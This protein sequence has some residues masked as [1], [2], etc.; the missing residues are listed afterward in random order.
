MSDKK[1]L[2]QIRILHPSTNT[3]V[4]SKVMKLTDEEYEQVTRN[5]KSDESYIDFIID[6]DDDDY[7]ERVYFSPSMLKECIKYITRYE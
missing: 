4:K 1:K 7:T 5:L 3:E 6:N 2:Y